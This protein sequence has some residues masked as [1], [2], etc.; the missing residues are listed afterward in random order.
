MKKTLATIA[1]LAASAMPGQASASVYEFKTLT[2]ECRIIATGEVVGPICGGTF[3]LDDVDGLRVGLSGSAG[4][5]Q[6]RTDWYGGG[7]YHEGSYYNSGVTYTNFERVGTMVDLDAEYCFGW[8]G[9]RICRVNANFFSDNLLDILLGSLYILNDSDQVDMWSDGSGLWSG[10]YGS[11]SISSR[12]QFFTG[13]WYEVP[14][15]GSLALLGVGL[16]GMM[17]LRQRRVSRSQC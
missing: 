11:D 17:G 8:S 4:E 14:E 13:V 15:P 9:P 7:A 3:G 12:R 6:I 16:L 10:F 2:N 5:L 1:L